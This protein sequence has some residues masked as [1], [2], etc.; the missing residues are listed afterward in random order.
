M[1][2][3]SDQGL[4][5]APEHLQR[6]AEQLDSPFYCYSRSRLEARLQA[7]KEAFGAHDIAVHFAMK[8]NSN[9]HILRI[10]AAHGLGVDLV[11]GGELLR[12]ATAGFPASKMI[13]SGVGKSAGELTAALHAGVGQINVESAEE[14]A[15]L[16]ELC[17]QLA[18][19]AQVAVRVNPDVVVATHANITTGRKG[20]KFGVSPE[21]AVSLCRQYAGHRWLKLNGL[22]MHIGSQ[23]SQTEPYAQ[24][25]QRLMTL[26]AELQLQGV[27]IDTLDLGGGFAVDYGDGNSL[28]FAE[29]AAVIRRATEGFSGRVCVEPGRSLV[30]DCGVLVSRVNY[31]KQAEPRSFVVL[32]AAMNDLM[33]PALYQAVHPMQLLRDSDAPQASFDVVGPVCESTD[34]FARNY[35]LPGDIRRGDLVALLCSGAYGAVMS[36]SYNS[37]A[38]IPEVLVSDQGTEII[39]QRISPEQMLAF[40]AESRLLTL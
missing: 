16:A 5:V 8:A 34:T 19:P 35:P 23:I 15:L 14:L 6:I 17:E 39:R 38:I 27:E 9:L 32:E 12:A 30:A 33:R 26:V 4:V 36:N 21:Q 31:V 3:Q 20:N 10:V 13:F 37:R 29:V 18:L 24:A 28:S 25:I 2:T 11:S 22:A 1:N 40:E 7:C